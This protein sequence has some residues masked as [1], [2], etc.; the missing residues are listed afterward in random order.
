MCW[1]VVR[2]AAWIVTVFF[3]GQAHC[4]PSFCVLWF[5]M[6]VWVGFPLVVL[7]LMGF[8]C[9]HVCARG[10]AGKEEEEEE[11]RRRRRRRG[12]GGFARFAEAKNA[13]GSVF[14][15][16]YSLIVFDSLYAQHCVFVYINILSISSHAVP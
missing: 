12:G 14:S 1:F 10:G 6:F 16:C 9:I 4:A 2:H 7:C 3:A 5:S 11:R 8:S 13:H 15:R